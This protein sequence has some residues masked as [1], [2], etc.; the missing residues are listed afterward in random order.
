MAGAQL[1]R[2]LPLAA[3]LLFGNFHAKGL[4]FHVF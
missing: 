3:D 2:L 4:R 1:A